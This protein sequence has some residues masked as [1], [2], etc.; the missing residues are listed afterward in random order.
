MIDQKPARIP[1]DFGDLLIAVADQLD[2]IRQ[3]VGCGADSTWAGLFVDEDTAVVNVTAW[4]DAAN[5]EHDRLVMSAGQVLA[6]PIDH[7]PALR[8]P[9]PAGT[10]R[11][12]E[13]RSPHPPGYDPD[14]GHDAVT[15]EGKCSICGA[16]V[17]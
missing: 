16:Q 9:L 7:L 2:E 5:C 11:V 15:F 1:I 14:C 3:C 6:Y 12:I 17:R 8:R 4:C 10:V 13:H